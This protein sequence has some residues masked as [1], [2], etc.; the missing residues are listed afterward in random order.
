MPDN[1]AEIAA[2][3]QAIGTGVLNVRVGEVS[4]TY[5]S[6]EDMLTARRFLVANDTSGNYTA[7]KRVASINL[8]GA[9]E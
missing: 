5:R 1:S 8:G 7:R 2:L 9:A 4:T 3:D 6:L